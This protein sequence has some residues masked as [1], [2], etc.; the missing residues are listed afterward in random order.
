[1]M[2]NPS[3]TYHAIGIAALL[4][5]LFPGI[6]LSRLRANATSS[7]A[8][9]ARARP[10]MQ[11]ATHQKIAKSIMRRIGPCQVEVSSHIVF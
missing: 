10:W 1:M 7:G 6:M 11:K 4:A 8:I 2:T 9:S 3:N 5:P